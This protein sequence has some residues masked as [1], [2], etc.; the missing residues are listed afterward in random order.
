MIAMVN[1][2]AMLVNIEVKL[3]KEM[4]CNHFDYLTVYKPVNLEN[5]EV[6]WE[7]IEE[8]LVNTLVMLENKW[9]T[10]CFHH[11]HLENMLVMLDLSRRFSFNDFLIRKENLLYVG[12]VGPFLGEKYNEIKRENKT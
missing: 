1:R 3:A 9:V 6:M 2:L 7:N 5:I 8:M 4:T 11:D 12:D 10:H